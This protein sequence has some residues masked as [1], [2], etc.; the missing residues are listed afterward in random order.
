[1]YCIKFSV[2]FLSPPTFTIA[3]VTIA[4][5]EAFPKFFPQSSNFSVFLLLQY[6]S[7]FEIVSQKYAL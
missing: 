5:E 6:V 4:V 7:N 1:M 3:I 2:I